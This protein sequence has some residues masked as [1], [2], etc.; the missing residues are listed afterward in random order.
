MHITYLWGNILGSWV[1]LIRKKKSLTEVPLSLHQV[2]LQLV[3]WHSVVSTQCCVDIARASYSWMIQE[4]SITLTWESQ[5]STWDFRGM[6]HSDFAK[7]RLKHP[8]WM[9]TLHI[10]KLRE[11]K[12]ERECARARKRER[13]RERERDREWERQTDRPANPKKCVFKQQASLYQSIFS[14]NGYFSLT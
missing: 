1:Y 9:F 7:C 4:V 5:G 14:S 6:Q 2:L 10:T 3:C 11:R 8:S 13:E 12:R